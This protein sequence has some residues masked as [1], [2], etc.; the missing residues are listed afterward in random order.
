MQIL[1]G[2]PDRVRQT[3]VEWKTSYFLA[4]CV[5]FS[6]TVR[7]TTEYYRWLIGSCVYVFDWLYGRWPWMTLNCYKFEVSHNYA[8]LRIFGWQQQLNEWSR[9]AVSATEL[10]HPSTFQRCRLRWYC[11][12]FYARNCCALV[13][14]LRRKLKI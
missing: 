1:T 5:A 12:A 3:R 11:S 6:K 4:L 9:P 7:D 10:L 13:V 14:V 8:L 2:S